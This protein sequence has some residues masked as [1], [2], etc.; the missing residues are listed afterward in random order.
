M[1]LIHLKSLKGSPKPGGQRQ[2]GQ[3]LIIAMIIL[4][5]LLILGF[6]FLGIV[7]RNIKGSATAQ[8]RSEANDLAEAGIRFAHAQLVDSP[9]GADWRGTPYTFPANTTLDPD[10][11]YLRPASYLAWPGSNPPRE[12]L[13][14][15]DGLGPYV[16]VSFDRGRALV[17][18]R[19]APSDANIFSSSP[20]GPL[21]NPGAVHSYL[22]IEAIGRTGVVRT[23]DPTTLSS[24]APV[25]IQGFAS[26]AQLQQA[27]GQL[28][29]FD[30]QFPNS[31]HLLAFDS[32][33]VI[34]YA[35]YITNKYNV[36]RAADIG[37]PDPYLG[38]PCSTTTNTDVLPG[39]GVF[40]NAG[41]DIDVGHLVAYQLGSIGSIANGN[42][43]TGPWTTVPPLGG[44]LMC[45]ADLQLHGSVNVFLNQLYGDK[46]L[47]N[48]NVTGD[49]NSQ[50]VLTETQLNAGVWNTPAPITLTAQPVGNSFVSRFTNYTTAG[51]SFL[52]GAARIDAAGYSRGVGRLAPPSILQ[53]D[54]QTKETRY[55]A[56][57]RESGVNNNG[58]NSGE[59]GHGRG[60]FVDN[61]A[62]IQIPT[63]EQGRTNSGERDSLI[64]DWLN[65]NSGDATSGWQG[66]FYVPV[67]AFV[68]LFSD[69]FQ[70]W[71]DNGQTFKNPDGTDPNP[72]S[73]TLRYRIGTYTPPGGVPQ[74][75]IVDGLETPTTINTATPD[76]S[77]GQ[78]FNGILY[79]EGNVR[80][81]GE[82]PTDA[83]ITLVSGA[84]IYIDGNITKGIH[85]NDVTDGLANTNP[86][87][88]AYGAA[89]TRP[90]KAALML[91]AKDY[92]A[93]NTT[94]FLGLAPG[95]SVQPVND[96]Q[97]DT[98]YNSVRITAGGGGNDGSLTFDEELIS[99]PS[100]GGNPN[101]P[102]LWQPYATNYID[103][104]TGNPMNTQLL[105]THTMD[106]GTGPATFISLYVNSGSP[107][108][109]DPS[110]AVYAFPGSP[111]SSAPW[112]TPTVHQTPLGYFIG[113]PNTAS[114]YLYNP[115]DPRYWGS[116]APPA[117]SWLSMYGLG[118]QTWQHYDK[119]ETRGFNLIYGGA[120]TNYSNGMITSTDGT[121]V[122]SVDPYI[123]YVLFATGNNEFQLRPNH[124]AG[125]ASNDYLL[126]RASLVPGDVRIEASI[127]AEE[128]SFFVIP[129]PWFNP[130]PN[131]TRDAYTASLSGSN[132]TQADQQRL[133][134]FGVGPET[135]FYG[136][137]LDVHVQVIGSVS[138]NMPPSLDVQNASTQKW[139][140]I[141]R[142]LG[143]DGASIPTSHI[144]SGM[145]N[146]GVVPN[147]VIEYDP[148]LATGR[149]DGFSPTNDPSGWV[150]TDS[151][152]RA[153]AP[154][155]RL[156]VSPV[157]TYFGELQ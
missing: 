138:E 155:P 73:S 26:V 105:L 71:L 61:K 112:W 10:A 95:Q 25:Q 18:V 48:G 74:T 77:K 28:Q 14:G 75:Y 34:D 157:P 133:D 151:F 85:G 37:I 144:P 4:G 119:F 64:N 109:G 23:S 6:V 126:A 92:V 134:N 103:S 115:T 65:P 66:P 5:L 70:I 47:I 33:G 118:R 36:T 132:Q 57:T 39:V 15:P 96:Q 2:R 46:W 69:G 78:P 56:A 68:K 44:S 7:D 59:F 131:D 20:T 16:R 31:R 93:V 136:E 21:R 72:K 135:P 42:A 97:N 52:D 76:F 81:R 11:Y 43:Q 139:G 24:G 152:G 113:L 140:W 38:D 22:Q 114:D 142:L 19:Y 9:L 102:S 13:G 98:G 32:T 17:R 101:N 107:T 63:N 106:D 3:T 87:Y 50:L 40:Y 51:G 150:R 55:L 79:F 147:V 108:Y 125:V 100:T 149:I 116:L 60:V 89:L 94:Q 122:G 90:S 110:W 67:G 80:V 88:A 156:P 82:I 137:P 153:L 84:T 53:I 83:Q 145:P 27:L 146:T 120:S 148:M 29:Q 104:G 99:D 143:A 123:Q 45:N 8:T 121:G 49:D 111:S 86:F 127:F 130:N 62:D 117:T 35:R 154:M 1:D 54:P 12:D 141:P 124:I 91:M 128:G 129:G 58:V 41:C 30:S